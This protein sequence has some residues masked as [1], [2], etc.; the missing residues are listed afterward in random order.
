MTTNNLRQQILE[1]LKILPSEQVKTLLLTWLTSSEGDLE[2]F[3][4][5]LTNQSLT[6]DDKLL[7]LNKLFGAWKDQPELME[8]FTEIDKERHAYR[9][10]SIE[11]IDGQDNG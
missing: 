2:D 5:L 9:G 11:S 8:I 3:E 1:H 10:R 6:D 4:R 7:K